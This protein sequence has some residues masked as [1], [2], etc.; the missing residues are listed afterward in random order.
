MPIQPCWWHCTRQFMYKQLCSVVSQPVIISNVYSWGESCRPFF[1]RRS[2]SATSALPYQ[3]LS[4]YLHS[5][6]ISEVEMLSLCIEDATIYDSN[7][8]IRLYCIWWLFRLNSMYCLPNLITVTLISWIPYLSTKL[9]YFIVSIFYD[10]TGHRGY[11]CMLNVLIF[12][13]L[14]KAWQKKILYSYLVINYS[15]KTEKSRF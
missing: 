14:T 4:S 11:P 13:S 5:R 8:S 12:F 1:H 6:N 15:F 9:R 2:W 10:F 7:G 3:W